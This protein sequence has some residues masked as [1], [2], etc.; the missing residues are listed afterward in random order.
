[1]NKPARAFAYSNLAFFAGAVVYVFTQGFIPHTEAA[2]TLATVILIGFMLVYGNL[3]FVISRRFTRKM[4]GLEFIPFLVAFL[5]VL[6]ALFLSYV[7]EIF[8]TDA[9]R[10]VYYAAIVVAAIAGSM[11]G[12]KAGKKQ[13]TAAS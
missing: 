2:N 7:T 8:R 12:T 6:P 9:A 10:Y 5:L 11:F 3:S 13:R 4:S 1:M